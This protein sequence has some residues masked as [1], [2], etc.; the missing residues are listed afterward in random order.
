MRSISYK[1]IEALVTVL[2]YDLAHGLPDEFRFRQIFFPSMDSQYK[3]SFLNG[4]DLNEFV[5]VS[6]KL[7]IITGNILDGLSKSMGECEASRLFDEFEVE[8]S[9]ISAMDCL[10]SYREG[11]YNG[12]RL[13]QFLSQ[14]LTTHV[15]ETELHN[16]I[17][18][19]SS[20]V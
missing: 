8:T 7:N 6:A 4:T 20:D 19:D 13:A 16:L 9:Y 14:E 5:N 2:K 1:D 12:Y 17:R 15:L 11:L 10:T 18:T 3:K